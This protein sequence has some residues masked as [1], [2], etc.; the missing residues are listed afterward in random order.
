MTD[1]DISKLAAQLTQNLATKEDLVNLEGR[2]TGLIEEVDH[3]TE[4]ILSV[5]DKVDE[6]VDDHEKRLKK[7]EAIPTI[8]HSLNK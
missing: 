7:I 5:V 6:T 8:A 4:M 3:K 1:E 2:L